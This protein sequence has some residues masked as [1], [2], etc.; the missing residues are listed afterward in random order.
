MIRFNFKSVHATC[1]SCNIEILFLGI[2]SA[3]LIAILYFVTK[4]DNSEEQ[5]KDEYL[6][7]G[8]VTFI[9]LKVQ[10][11]IISNYVIK[12]MKA[13]ANKKRENHIKK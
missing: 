8:I 10:N 4:K 13:K 5:N 3:L 6:I 7:K 2:I 1:Y 11:L 9:K 12:K